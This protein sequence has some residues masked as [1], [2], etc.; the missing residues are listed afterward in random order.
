MAKGS[1]Q[2]E[3]PPSASTPAV[4]KQLLEEFEKFL[5]YHPAG[6]LSRNLRRL[7]LEFMMYDGS[8]EACYLKDLLFDLEG[9]FELLDT[10]EKQWPS[11]HN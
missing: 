2:P 5:E 9:L 10:A 1:K 6:R 4:N 3:K 11:E 8:L 7:I